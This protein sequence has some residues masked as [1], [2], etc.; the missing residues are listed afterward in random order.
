[1]VDRIHLGRDDRKTI[2]DII[3]YGLKHRE[4]WVGGRLALARSLQM[5][6]LPDPQAFK[7]QSQ[8][9]GGVVLHATQLTGEGRGSEEGHH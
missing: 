5:S 3:Q 4:Q 9:R 8:Q 2:E 7:K 1:M 6:D